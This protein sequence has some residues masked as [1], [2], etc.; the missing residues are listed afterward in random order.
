MIVPVSVV[1]VGVGTVSNTPFA[2]PVPLFVMT[3]VKSIAS[4][5]RARL[6]GCAGKASVWVALIVGVWERRLAP[7]KSRVNATR[8]WQALRTNFGERDLNKERE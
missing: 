5:S 8:Q 3:V 7:P 2:G 4:F 1:F 6:S